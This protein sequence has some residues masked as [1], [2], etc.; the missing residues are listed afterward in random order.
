LRGVLQPD[1]NAP[2]P[3]PANAAARATISR[4]R[5]R[6]AAARRIGIIERELIGAP[7]GGKPPGAACIDDAT[8]IDGPL[9]GMLGIT[10]D[11]RFVMPASYNARQATMQ[12]TMRALL[13]TSLLLSAVIALTVVASAQ[14]AAKPAPPAPAAATHK[15]IPAVTPYLIKSAGSLAEIE[16][17]LLGPGG[18]A[19]TLV[20]PTAQ[21]ALQIDWRHEENIEAGGYE[22]HDGRDHVFFI[23]EGNGAFNLG[24]ELEAPTEPSPGEWRAKKAK[25]THEVAVAKGDVVFIPHG[26][27]HGRAK[28][29]KFTML[30]LS[31]WP[32]GAPAAAINPPPAKK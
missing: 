8:T 20:P 30:L 28:G 15:P 25:G 9:A 27:V 32:G 5:R 13:T 16:K 22:A 14:P 29:G 7:P 21:V 11:G 17:T 19:S 3:R 24:G 12:F 1:A 31:F 4:C 2:A 18:H 23:T 26:T 6:I 10:G